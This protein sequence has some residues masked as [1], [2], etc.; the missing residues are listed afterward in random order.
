MLSEEIRD[1]VQQA[2]RGVGD[3]AFLVHVLD[4]L[5]DVA[6]RC[7]AMEGSAIVEMPPPPDNVV[8]IDGRRRGDG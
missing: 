3:P 1:L 7:E 4:R 8:S 6:A 2:R 5:D